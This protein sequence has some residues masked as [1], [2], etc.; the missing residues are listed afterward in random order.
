MG[1][2]QPG[3]DNGTVDIQKAVE[4]QNKALWL[5]S[6][7]GPLIGL[8]WPPR[9]LSCLL[10]FLRQTRAASVGGGWAATGSMN[11]YP[12]DPVLALL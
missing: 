2:A 11:F 6:P 5:A 1:Y 3:G 12:L 10:A 4:F 8:R 9:S 7:Q